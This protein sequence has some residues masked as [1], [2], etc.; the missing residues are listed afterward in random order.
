MRFFDGH[1]P[2]VDVNSWRNAV[3]RN[4]D[5]HWSEGRSAALLARSWLAAGGP[6]S[7]VAEPLQL[8]IPGVSFEQGFI[9]HP[10]SVPG[11]GAASNTDLLALGSCPAGVVV[12]AVEGK[13]DEIFGHRI[14]HWLTMGTSP[15][16]PANRTQRWTAMARDLGLEGRPLDWLPY[17]LL[18]RTW[19]A[20]H[21]GKTRGAV[22][23][24]IV[25]HSFDGEGRT[26]WRD[27]KAFAGLMAPQA[28]VK[29][30]VMIPAAISPPVLWLL[31]SSDRGGR[32]AP[33]PPCKGCEP[34]R[35][36]R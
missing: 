2:A 18:H 8:A 36:P 13:V 5:K 12:L 7:V 30:D 24:A 6:P 9:E 11:Q 4:S 10:T 3:L 20:L 14:G 1:R 31:W 26:G 29:P 27:F 22:H 16:S 34:Y 35:Q 21:E 32:P 15:G 28:A 25:V 19:V 23:A 33:P 17:Q